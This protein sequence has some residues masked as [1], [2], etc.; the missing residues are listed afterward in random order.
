[1]DRRASYWPCFFS[2]SFIRVISG[3]LRIDDVLGDLFD[4]RILA[5]GEHR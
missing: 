4:F 2:H 5:E 3:L 1:M